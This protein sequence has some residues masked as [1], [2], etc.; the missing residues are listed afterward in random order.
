MLLNIK[1]DI[2]LITHIMRLSGETRVAAKHIQKWLE[3]GQGQETWLGFYGSCGVRD[4]VRVPMHD[5]SFPLVL[6][7]GKL[8]FLI[9]G[10]AMA[11]RGKKRVRLRKHQKKKKRV[12]FFTIK[13]IA[14][15]SASQLPHL[16][17]F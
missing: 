5:L 17:N 7:D 6:K 11:F 3:R 9:S 12:R 15:I 13:L 1:G 2:Y 16:L 4:G 10:P 14:Q 8:D